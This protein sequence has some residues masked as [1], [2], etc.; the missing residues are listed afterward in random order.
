MKKTFTILLLVLAAMPLMA[1][2]RSAAERMSIARDVLETQLGQTLNDHQ[3]G[4]A[5]RT[6][7]PKAKA[8][9]EQ[10][11]LRLLAGSEQI[12]SG[13][14]VG[15][16]FS[17]YGYNDGRPGFVIV[18]SDDQAHPVLAY[19][20]T[21]CFDLSK[22]PEAAADLLRM[23]ARRA[24]ANDLAT[25]LLTQPERR[26]ADGRLLAPAK[27]VAPL[28]GD[29]S[30]DQRA[31][32]Y[33]LCPVYDGKRCLTGCTATAMSQIMAY[34]K[35]PQRMN[36]A[37]GSTISYTTSKNGI[38]ATWNVSSTQ[39][40]WQNI[41][42]KYTEPVEVM[43][44]VQFNTSHTMSLSGFDYDAS[45]PQY[46]VVTKL[47]NISKGTF[48]GSVR[49]FVENESGKVLGYAGKASTINDLGSYYYYSTYHLYPVLPSDL[50]DGTYRIFAATLANGSYFW[51]RVSNNDGPDYVTVQKHGNSF[52]LAGQEFRCGYNDA[53]GKAA[54]T[55]SGA[56]AYSLQADFGTGST[57][58]SIVN[59]ANSLIDY[60]DYSNRLQYVE[61]R[62]FSTDGWHQYLQAELYS[63][64]PVFVSGFTAD[65]V[66]G[67][68]FIIDGCQ[69]KNGVPYYH[70]NW[71]WAGKSD[72]YFLVDFLKPS[73]AGD[74]G[75][76]RNYG[77]DVTLIANIKPKDSDASIN[78]FGA[79][80]LS[81]SQTNLRENQSLVVYLYNLTNCSFFTT[82]NIRFHAV[83]TNPWGKVYD[84][85]KLFSINELKPRYFYNELSNF[86]KIPS[87][88]PTGDYKLE[89]RAYDNSLTRYTVVTAPQTITLHLTT[90]TDASVG[91]EGINGAGQKTT[92]PAYDLNGRP[93]T[94]RT[95]GIVVK[96][97]KKI[98]K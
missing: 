35:H 73:E 22:M 28:L 5:G 91:I 15:D 76:E 87:T 32:F 61:P 74:G 89:V 21:S 64:R 41:L 55:L 59:M 47:M 86:V 17:V 68:A 24:Q 94:T 90:S 38:S 93:A 33:N 30:F 85:G 95:R 37:P 9:R 52:T 10:D 63:K 29:I 96:D 57:S 49:L 23:Y 70:V 34:H 46:I 25:S 72:G 71:G 81:V 54:A 6:Q 16:V 84:L 42:H 51:Q 67:H 80:E 3:A 14:A 69:N 83:L 7:S 27:T 18:S 11:E 97:G 56:C 45:W 2:R 1:Q 31:P 19:S 88:V 40:D 53:Q 82:G 58:G 75:Y 4:A 20:T 92:S 48:N 43:R 13:E 66:Y 12:L 26:T 78:L 36:T 8:V 60:M 65:Q 79:T 77:E 50:A 44:D 98:A 62:F 39:F